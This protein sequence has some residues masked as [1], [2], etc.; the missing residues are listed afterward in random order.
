MIPAKKAQLGGIITI[1]ISI[2]IIVAVALPITMNLVTPTTIGTTINNT[3]TFTNSQ[4]TASYALNTYIN[5][6]KNINVTEYSTATTANF[7]GKTN[8]TAA[9]LSLYING[10]KTNTSTA[11][12]TSLSYGKYA[13]NY[14]KSH[15]YKFTVSSNETGYTNTTYWLILKPEY[16]LTYSPN[17]STINLLMYLIPL[18]IAILALIIV[19]KYMGFF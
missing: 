18:F 3:Y 14:T 4:G 6:Y 17:S 9:Y 16:Y 11:K 10:V 8:G 7:T 5:E 15:T 12:V 19:A 1:L 13:L 2:I